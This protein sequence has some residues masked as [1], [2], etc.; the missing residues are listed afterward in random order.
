M[1][2]SNWQKISADRDTEMKTLF[3]A[4]AILRKSI[5]NCKKWKF[6]GSLEL[7]SFFRWV[8]QGPNNF[9]SAE[10]KCD[11]VHKRS[12][13]LAQSTVSLC[14]TERQIKYK[15]SETL[16]STAEMPQQLAVGLAVQ[17]A[18]RSKELISML[19]GFVMLADYNR[20]LRV[21]VQIESSV[22]KCMAQND[23]VYLPPDIVEGRHVFYAVDNVDFA[24]DTPDGKRTFHGIAMA[25]YQRSDPQDKEP[26]LNVDTPDQSRSISALH[27]SITS[28]PGM[29]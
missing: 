3:D 12:M 24:E 9:L 22:L 21:E 19:H 20:I 28:L 4:A 6:T 25:I 11:E 15:K 17:R 18:V 26:D 10:K 13:S 29:S 8:I 7:Y 23:G 1:L 16:R 2:Q 27:E 5:S 14:L